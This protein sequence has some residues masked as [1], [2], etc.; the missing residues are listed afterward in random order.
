MA[1]DHLT[2][3]NFVAHPPFFKVYDYWY[4]VIVDKINDISPTDGQIR[5]DGVPT[6][7]LLPSL[8][9]GLY[10]TP[11]VETAT[12]DNIA[13]TVNMSTATNKGSA[14]TSSMAAYIGISNTAST[15]NAK[16]QG[17]LVGTRVG[18]DVYAAYGVQSNM[19]LGAYDLDGNG[20][21]AAISGKIT[22]GKAHD[23]GCIAAGYFTIDGAFTP[24][25]N[26]Y[27][28]WIDIVSSVIT[29]GLTIAGTGT[30][31]DAIS[32]SVESTNAIKI[33]KG[34]ILTTHAPHGYLTP[35]IGIGVYGTPISDAVAADNIAFTVNIR[36][37][38]NKSTNLESSMAAYIGTGNTATTAT[39]KAC[40]QGI[41]VT[42]TIAN[43]CF[44]A[45]GVQANMSATNIGE[46]DANGMMVSLAGSITLA[47]GNA[48]GCIAP[49]YFILQA[50][51]G[52]YA[53]GATSYGVWIDVLG[54]TGVTAGLT[55]AVNAAAS[56]GAGL[57]FS[58]GA[59]TSFKHA[60]KFAHNDK[61]EGAF[62]AEIT[63][64]AKADGM[65][66][67]DVAGTNYYIP[68]W[69]DAGIDNEWVD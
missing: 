32:I 26:T 69:N 7:Y 36:S 17:V 60:F 58:G 10:G 48:S 39:P 27:G 52:P 47:H 46:V 51:T 9:V 67:I 28:V 5:L 57:Y 62:V 4:N 53:M 1:L 63:F 11:V 3:K 38:I 30:C 20:T 55:V 8:A 25:T 66:K 45:Y 54:L 41:L 16:L 13:F 22:L 35:S 43:S 44:S 68:F 14:D 50:D 15:P 33:T 29:A 40:L 19:I 31:T 56:V 12:I 64:D 24:V 34:N 37:T 6:S 59:T 49:G 42:N 65:I 21:A 2:K 18:G 23:A 61:S